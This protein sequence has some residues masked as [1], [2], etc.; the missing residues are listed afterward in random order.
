[1]N[2]KIIFII[3]WLIVSAFLVG[4]LLGCKGQAKESIQEGDFKVELLFEKD[5]CKMYRFKD[6]N[7]YIYWSDCSGKVQSDVYRSTGKGSGY[8]EHM[9]SITN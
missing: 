8:T 5:G 4:L 7:R 9:E 2:G 6:G 1:M 3:S